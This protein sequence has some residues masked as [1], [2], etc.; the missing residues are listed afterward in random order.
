MPP[1]RRWATGARSTTPGS[2][3]GAPRADHRR[4]TALVL[5]RRRPPRRRHGATGGRRRDAVRGVGQPAG[6]AAA[7][8]HGRERPVSGSLLRTQG[9]SVRY[10][11]VRALD[12]VSLSV[13]AG[14]LVGLI[15]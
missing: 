14:S 11:G 3:R 10:G 5:W 8:P 12:D 1:T 15:G 2:G 4:R 7:G 9:L 6:P 13:G